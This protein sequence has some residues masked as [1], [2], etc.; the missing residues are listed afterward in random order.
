M[1]DSGQDC[2]CNAAWSGSGGNWQLGVNMRLTAARGDCGCT[3]NYVC[4]WQNQLIVGVSVCHPQGDPTGSQ[5]VCLLMGA[6]SPREV[7]SI[8]FGQSSTEK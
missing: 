6:Q 2:A 7:L 3:G 4:V 5:L 1:C 8:W